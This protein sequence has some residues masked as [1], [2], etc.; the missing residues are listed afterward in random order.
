VAKPLR[1]PLSLDELLQPPLPGDPKHVVKLADEAAAIAQ[2]ETPTDRVIA[3]S[4]MANARVR[5]LRV[6]VRKNDART[7]ELAQ[8]YALLLNDGIGAVVSDADASESEAAQRDLR[9]LAREC[10]APDAPVLVELEGSTEG[11]AKESVHAAL[12][13]CRKIVTE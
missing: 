9:K 13:A 6:A 12:V 10:L 2:A 5:E 4:E 7:T 8:A 1:K 11:P 3:F